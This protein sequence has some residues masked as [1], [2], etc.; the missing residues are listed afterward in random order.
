MEQVVGL[1]SKVCVIL[2]LL[3]VSVIIEE[4]FSFNR[5]FKNL[6]ELRSI[7]G[8]DRKMRN[9]KL[10]SNIL[11]QVVQGAL[12][13]ILIYFDSI[14]TMPNVA[15][16]GIIYDAR[17]VVINLSAIYGPIAATITVLTAAIIRTI[18]NIN[19]AAIPVITIMVIYI[20]E[21]FFLYVL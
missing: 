1:I 7:E 17:E 15:D 8:F 6:Y 4:Y 20:I 10:S 16:G 18:K 13:A 21:M 14:T 9:R 5:R 11:T 19:S 12:F 3:L 2:I